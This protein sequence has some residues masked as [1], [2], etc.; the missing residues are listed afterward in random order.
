MNDN[1]V[2]SYHRANNFTRLVGDFSKVQK[3]TSFSLELIPLWGAA[4]MQSLIHRNFWHEAIGADQDVSQLYNWVIT[5]TFPEAVS[6]DVIQLLNLVGALLYPVALNLSLPLFLYLLV[7]EK[8]SRVKS[9]MEF[10]GMSNVSYLASNWIFFI[11]IYV[12][13][14]TLFWIVGAA[15]NLEVFRAT[16]ITTM[17]LFWLLWGLALISLSFFFSAFINTKSAATMVATWWRWEA[18][19]LPPCLPWEYT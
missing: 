1:Y 5:M 13:L 17:G 19:C 18:P 6:A 14:A 11:V 16:A 9:L 10:H 4:Q 12:L 15:I 7:M 3:A 8:Q 2:V